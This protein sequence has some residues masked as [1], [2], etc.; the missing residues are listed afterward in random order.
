MQLTAELFS[1]I[2]RSPDAG[3]LRSSGGVRGRV[4]VTVFFAPEY[5]GGMP[6]GSKL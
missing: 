5:E 6:E 4:I 3:A 2:L 1:Q